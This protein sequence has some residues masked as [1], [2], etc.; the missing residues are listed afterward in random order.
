MKERWPFQQMMMMEQTDIYIH[1]EKWS[2]R[3]NATSFTMNNPICITDFNIK[4][5]AIRF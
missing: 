4:C 2:I 3:L 5:K 1:L